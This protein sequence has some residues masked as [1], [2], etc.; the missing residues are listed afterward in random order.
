[1][2]SKVIITGGAGFIGSNLTEHWLSKE[3]QVTVFDNLSR[4]GGG[5][6]K[7]I[8]Y[9]LNK[10]KGNP[11]FEFVLGDVRNLEQLKKAMKDVDTVMHV[12]AQ[13]AMTT[14][15]E[16][17]VGDF[18]TNARGT[19][20]V[21]EA[22]ASSG[23]DPIVIYTST[24]KVYGDLTR[25]PVKLVEKEKRWD[26]V[27]EEYLEGIDEDYP[28]DFEGP[29]GCSKGV[30]D[31]YCLDY[32]RT[33]GLKTVVFRMSGIYGMGQHPTEDQGWVALF[34]RRAIEKKPITIY[35]DGKQVR[36]ILFITDLLEAFDQAMKNIEHTKGQAYNIGGGRG[37]SISILE[38]LEFL[39]KDLAIKPSEVSFGP[40]RLADQKLYISNTQRAKREFG[41]EPK[42][43]KE[44]GIKRLYEWMKRVDWDESL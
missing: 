40:W 35:G 41:W 33:F 25:K 5:A 27:N 29:Y 2:K 44:E 4:P 31:A 36:D 43:S 42:V 26:F 34:I 38:L 24:N 23:S 9:L 14:S 10:Y 20:N 12:A 3:C 1:M 32:A 13:T 21:L 8:E 22:A 28:L 30:G 11:S 18:E 19:F 15:I 6:K 17:P 37:N 39:E 7:N 16:D